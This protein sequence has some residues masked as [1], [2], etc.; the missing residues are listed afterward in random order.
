MI[1]LSDG[2]AIG[3]IGRLS[4]KVA[5]SY[6]FR[7]AI[8][9]AEL[10][11]NRLLASEARAVQYKPLPRFP[12][13]MRDMTLLVDRGI[14]LAELQSAIDTQ[15]V[16]DYRGAQ[17]VGTYEGPNIPA[18][19]R[20]VTLRIEYRSDERTLRDDVVEERQRALIDSLLLKFDAQLH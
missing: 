19:R 2:T 5:D 4:E 15:Q 14:T 3:T 13:V 12:S 16:D 9:I 6:K 11:L 17:L 20:T 10:D 1:M 8:Y 18:G 7:Q